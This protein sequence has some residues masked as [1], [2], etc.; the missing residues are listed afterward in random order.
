ME[1]NIRFVKVFTPYHERHHL[2]YFF[3]YTDELGELPF[4]TVVQ[5]SMSIGII[6][7]ENVPEEKLPKVNF[8]CL[9]GVADEKQVKII[10]KQWWNVIKEIHSQMNE[11]EYKS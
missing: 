3:Y 8:S 1:E 5:T 11:I 9:Y 4:G 6:I 2:S 7:D 10:E